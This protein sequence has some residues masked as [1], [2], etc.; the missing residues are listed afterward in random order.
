MRIVR[1]DNGS[2]DLGRRS[3]R[4]NLSHTTGMDCSCTGIGG[5]EASLKLNYVL[6]VPGQQSAMFRDELLT[7][8]VPERQ[9]YE[10][11]AVALQ[12]DER[13]TPA[14]GTVKGGSGGGDRNNKPSSGRPKRFMPG[15]IKLGTYVAD[16]RRYN[17]CLRWGSVWI[18]AVDPTPAEARPNGGPGSS[19][20]DGGEAS[21]VPA[22][23]AVPDEDGGGG[24]GRD[25][26][27]GVPAI[28]PPPTDADAQSTTGRGDD[29]DDGGDF[30]DYD[31][32]YPN[33]VGNDG[34]C[35]SS[36][37]LCD[38]CRRWLLSEYFGDR[39]RRD[40]AS[41]RHACVYKRIVDRLFVV[42]V[43]ESG[44]GQNGDGG[45]DDDDDDGP[46]DCETTV[47]ADRAT[48]EVAGPP[49]RDLQPVDGPTATAAAQP[50]PETEP[51]TT[52]AAPEPAAN[53]DKPKSKSFF[54][55]LC[56][57]KSNKKKKNVEPPKTD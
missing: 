15:A 21:E 20:A 10:E 55:K 26:A 19:M 47:G 3:L 22:P 16:G 44:A 29:C 48:S 49:E 57:K 40:K 30:D 31:D 24:G 12:H 35:N 39:R 51:A 56:S 2:R 18:S 52:T 45:E 13:P 37:T 6:V 42:T 17:V 9:I 7:R 46:F 1:A 53:V 54:S 25:G 28:V 4:V 41:G 36:S 14:A 50:A 32:V 23:V 5:L 33:P 27:D 38:E 11:T 43:T 34:R 8:G